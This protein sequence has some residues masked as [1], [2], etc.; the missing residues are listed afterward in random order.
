MQEE[1]NNKL[2]QIL[3]LLDKLCVGDEV[4]HEMTTHTD[5]LP[6]S[7]LIKQLQSNL[8]KTYH[9]EKTQGNFPGAAINVTKRLSR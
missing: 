1:D 6:K 3:F 9:I 4:Y 5:G 2:E 8:D 7:Y